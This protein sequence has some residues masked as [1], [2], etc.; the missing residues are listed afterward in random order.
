MAAV[1]PIQAQERSYSLPVRPA[2]ELQQL[3]GVRVTWLHGPSASNA[4]ITIVFPAVTLAVADSISAHFRGQR[5][6]DPFPIDTAQWQSHSSLYDLAPYPQLYRYL[7]APS[8]EYRDG[9]YDVTIQIT[10]S[11]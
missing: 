10:T 9:L 11:F 8:R 3:G 7:A 1:P 6:H 4:P 5:Q 2:S